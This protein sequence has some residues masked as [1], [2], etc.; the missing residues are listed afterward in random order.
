MNIQHMGNKYVAW[1]QINKPRHEH[2]DVRAHTNIYAYMYVLHVLLTLSTGQSIHRLS[3]LKGISLRYWIVPGDV[4]ESL[5]E[6]FL[7]HGIILNVCITKQHLVRV[8]LCS[9]VKFSFSPFSMEPI[10]VNE[11]G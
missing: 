11:F 7:I 5:N 1:H 10:R 9:R 2:A 4:Y 8:I 3:I 6:A